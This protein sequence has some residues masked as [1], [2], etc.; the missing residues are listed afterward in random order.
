MRVSG[1]LALGVAVTCAAVAVPP[2]HG[3]SALLCAVTRVVECSSEGECQ[4]STIET[5]NLPRFIRVNPDG[6]TLAAG[7][8][9]AR[10]API[11]SV[12]RRNDR[13]ILHGGQQGRAW[14]A[15]VADKTGE[16]SVAVVED[17][18]VFVIF[19]ACTTPDASR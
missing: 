1:L 15:T 19:G 4:R 13:L 5:A 8:A 9:D 7:G 16:M 2:A 11:Q 14:S 10:T 18:T 17:H 3:S 6:R 12:D